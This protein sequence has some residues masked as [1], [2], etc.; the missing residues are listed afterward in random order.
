MNGNLAERKF[1]YNPGSS[2]S[3]PLFSTASI[4]KE[5]KTKYS[6]GFR[7]K[8]QNVQSKNI[9]GK[10]NKCTKSCKTMGRTLLNRIKMKPSKKKPNPH[11]IIILR[12]MVELYKSAQSGKQK[13]ESIFYMNE[14]AKRN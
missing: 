9:E 4:V 1:C 6:Q 2:I 5:W 13:I 10:L 8:D 14:M 3:P 11:E 12:R 7:P